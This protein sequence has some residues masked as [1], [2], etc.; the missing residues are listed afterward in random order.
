VA[1]FEEALKLLE[2]IPATGQDIA[3][4]RFALA[5]GRYATGHHAEA[6]AEPRRARTELEAAG[7]SARHALAEAREWLARHERRALTTARETADGRR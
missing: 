5:R 1:L 6:L 3:E 2:S 4:A 7:E